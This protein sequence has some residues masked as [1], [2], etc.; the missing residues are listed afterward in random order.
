LFI[1]IPAVFSQGWFSVALF[2][3][4]VLVSVSYV[5]LLSLTTRH[6]ALL[7]LLR[8]FKVPRL[9]VFT[10]GMTYRYIYLFAEIIENTYLAIKSRT[11]GFRLHHTKGRE[12][13]SWNIATLW[14]RSVQLSEEV[15][16]AML[17]RGYTGEPKVMG[18]E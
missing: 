14:Q 15:Y 4:R 11:G 5:V 7:K 16:L 6:T 1:A 10:I 3:M 13:V 12:V 17:A 2:V 9:F 8:F 18:E